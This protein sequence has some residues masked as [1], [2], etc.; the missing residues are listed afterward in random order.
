VRAVDAVS[1]LARRHP[2]CFFDEADIKVEEERTMEKE[3]AFFAALGIA[4][5]FQAANGKIGLAL[6]LDRGD[7]QRGQNGLVTCKDELVGGTD[8]AERAR[9][10]NPQ[11]E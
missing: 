2:Q 6:V 7:D 1:G 8:A 3:T 9:V 11:D 5:E 10:V 4:G